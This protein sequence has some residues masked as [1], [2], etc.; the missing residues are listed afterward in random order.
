MELRKMVEI[1]RT[2]NCLADMSLMVSEVGAFSIIGGFD[3]KFK[4]IFGSNV[5]DLFTLDKPKNPVSKGKFM[6]LDFIVDSDLGKH[7]VILS[8][9]T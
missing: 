6:G 2:V 5:L 3:Q 7:E 4:F 9:A 8:N 1:K